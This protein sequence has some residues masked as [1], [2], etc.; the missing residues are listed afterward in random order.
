ML[1]KRELSVESIELDGVKYTVSEMTVR[2]KTNFEAAVVHHGAGCIREAL[3][4]YC[5]SVNGQPAFPIASKL[6]EVDDSLAPK[7]ANGRPLSEDALNAWRD[8]QALGLL[9]E[10]LATYPAEQVEPLVA[11]AQKVNPALGNG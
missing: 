3:L 2:T 10:D 6:A 5:V 1:A 9:L 8:E 4:V 11:L 7:Q